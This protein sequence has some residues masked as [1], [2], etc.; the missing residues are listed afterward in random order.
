MRAGYVRQPQ[1]NQR[2]ARVFRAAHVPDP[3][4]AHVSLADTDEWQLADDAPDIRGFE[5]LDA[6][7][8]RLGRVEHLVVDTATGTVSTV[9]LDSGTGVPTVSLT[10]GD[11]VV[12]LSARTSEAVAR[13]GLT[14]DA[15]S[16]RD[17]P[18]GKPETGLHLRVVPRA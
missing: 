10:L 15:S 3:A 8:A 7:G 5:A 2:A 4:M 17:S 1:A 13:S 12:T 16:D 6:D 14:P 9:L 18:T 11:G